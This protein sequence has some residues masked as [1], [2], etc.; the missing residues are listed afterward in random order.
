MGL[1]K[2]SMLTLTSKNMISDARSGNKPN[3]DHLKVLSMSIVS[4]N[5]KIFIYSSMLLNRQ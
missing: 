4:E 2:S 3:V 5:I 1:D